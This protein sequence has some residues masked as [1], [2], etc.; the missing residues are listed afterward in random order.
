V[1]EGVESAVL[2]LADGVLG[3][4]AIAVLVMGRA[5]AN[6]GLIAD[7]VARREPGTLAKRMHRNRQ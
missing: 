3:R 5:M 6:E 7:V 2:M 1:V 4:R